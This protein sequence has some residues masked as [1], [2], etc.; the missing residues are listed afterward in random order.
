MG[1]ILGT[2]RVELRG[3]AR[4]FGDVEAPVVVVE[5]GVL[6]EGHC[7][8]TKGR[9][10][11]TPLAVAAPLPGPDPDPSRSAARPG[12]GDPQALSGRPAY[13]TTWSRASGARTSPGVKSSVTMISTDALPPSPWQP[14]AARVGLPRSPKS[15]T[16]QVGGAVDDARLVAEARRRVDVADHV[17]E[18]LHPVEIAQRVLHRG[19]RGQRR[20]AGRLVALL[21]V[22]SL[23]TTPG[24]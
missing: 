23:P 6:F 20:V 16:K 7:R 8:M 3:T 11:R 12:R 24:R 4:V 19:Q 1:N 17:D 15:S 13:F 2:E 10:E 18:L 14:M 21:D 9:A 22:R 5:E